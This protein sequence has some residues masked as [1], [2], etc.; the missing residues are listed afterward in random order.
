ML[1]PLPILTYD[2][3]LVGKNYLAIPYISL[4]FVDTLFLNTFLSRG[5]ENKSC[6]M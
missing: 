6:V 2:L 5:E 4:T 3:K 1:P